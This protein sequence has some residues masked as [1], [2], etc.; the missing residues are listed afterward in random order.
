MSAEE[1]K[2]MA[3]FTFKKLINENCDISSF[4]CLI[5][6]KGWKGKEIEYS[7][8]KFADYVYQN[9]HLTRTEQ[10]S[11]FAI[12]SRMVTEIPANFCSN[13][14]NRCR[15]ICKEKEDIQH[16]YN[17]KILN[18]NELKIE[19][20]EIFNENLAKQKMIMK[21]FEENMKTRNEN[22]NPTNEPCDPVDP[23]SFDI[24]DRIG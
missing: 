1:T 21:R 8:L 11:I 10:R 17:C 2:I 20:E 12:R 22:N 6:T 14:N 18:K 16:I 24:K 3:A 15:C 7:K 19:F 9:D 5:S 13:E 23:L 4:N